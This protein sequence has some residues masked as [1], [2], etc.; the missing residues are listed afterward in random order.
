MS[1]EKAE[2][3]RIAV[4][5]AGLSGAMVA[6]LIQRLQG[7]QIVLIEKRNDN[8]LDGS[9]SAFGNL[10]NSIKRSINL[11]LS[12]RGIK[13]LNELGLTKDAMA[14]GIRMPK[15]VIHGRNGDISLQ[16]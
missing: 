10:T 16:Y 9:S 6:A 12:Y 2:T 15:R 14:E 3:I 13:A 1:G 7:F 4:V 8:P 11:A 5:G